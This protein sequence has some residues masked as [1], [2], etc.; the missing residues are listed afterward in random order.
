MAILAPGQGY[1]AEFKVSVATLSRL[2]EVEGQ[3][4]TQALDIDH[5]MQSCPL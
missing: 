2:P 3:H 5:P 4:V 1:S